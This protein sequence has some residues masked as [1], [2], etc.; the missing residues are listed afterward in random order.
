MNKIELSV[1]VPCYN[2][3]KNIPLIIDKLKKYLDRKNLEFILVDNGSTD[4]TRR[5]IQKYSKIYKTIKLI[6]VEKNIGYGNGIYNGLK[7]AKG[8]FI[9]WT[10]ADLQTDPNDIFKAFEIIK[11]QKNPK[12]SFIKGNRTGRPFFD[13]FFEFGMS[14]FETIILKTIIYD[15]N[16]Q[17]NLFDKSFLKLMKSPPK[18]FSFDLYAY[19]LAK[20]NGYGV[21]RFPVFFPPRIHGESSWNTGWKQRTKFI[22][23]TI[24]FTF[25]LK[26]YLKNVNYKT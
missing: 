25:K 6:I 4:G 2:E 21:I 15:I 26:K 11:K 7:S 12:K 9:G 3:E 1:I 24:D 18:D 13:K 23:R 19:Y 5:E 8:E 16:A 10:H 14:V 17:P 20:I 22:K